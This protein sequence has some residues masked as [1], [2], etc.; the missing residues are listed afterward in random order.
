VPPAAPPRAARLDTPGLGTSPSS[1]SPSA[2]PPPIADDDDLPKAPREFERR[3]VVVGGLAMAGFA[4]L[5][6]L[7]GR[8]TTPAATA[9]QHSGPALA[10]QLAVAAA[11]AAPAAALPVPSAPAAAAPAPSAAPAPA[12]PVAVSPAVPAA[13]APAEVPPAPA[14]VPAPAAPVAAAP[15][16]APASSQEASAAPWEG[17]LA[18]AEEAEA[19]APAPRA[20]APRPTRAARPAARPAAAAPTSD[21]RTTR[22]RI[23]GL[24]K[25]AMA[26]YERLEPQRALEQLRLALRLCDEVTLYQREIAALTHMNL[27]VVL[28]GGFK[29]RELA[30]RHFR[31]ARALM[32]AI[33]PSVDSESPEIRAAFA[34]ATRA[35]R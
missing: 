18:A 27:G 21:A 8:A 1:P 31:D 25:T 6:F 13:A 32:P 33:A 5:L 30:V 16:A 29:Q 19:P 4:G 15:T 14:S 17:R 35:A 7:L 12:A 11:P 24:N 20:P 3:R 23:L 28:A 9:A 2:S 10:R 26:A 22:D 34:E